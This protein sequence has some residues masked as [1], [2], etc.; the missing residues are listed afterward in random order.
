V[1][2]E[3]EGGRQA[4]HKQQHCERPQR[5]RHRRDCPTGIGATPWRR[6]PTPAPV[7]A[8]H[9]LEQVDRADRARRLHRCSEVDALA[10]HHLCAHTVTWTVTRTV[11]RT[12]ARGWQA[13]RRGRQAHLVE[14]RMVCTVRVVPQPQHGRQL[15]AHHAELAANVL[16]CALA[17]PPRVRHDLLHQL[18]LRDA[19]PQ[20]RERDLARTPTHPHTSQV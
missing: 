16:R 18:L 13:G 8:P 9:R 7:D 2:G 10:S 5:Q 15:R 17:G 11:T 4:H 19:A 20:I 3:R 14:L 6:R 1:A 12:G